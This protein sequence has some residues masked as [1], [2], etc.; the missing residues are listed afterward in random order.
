MGTATPEEARE[1]IR[2]IQDKVS[3]QSKGGSTMS[4]SEAGIND[5]T[6]VREMPVEQVRRSIE[7]VVMRVAESI[8]KGEAF[9][10]NVPNRSSSNQS[11]IPELDRV[12]LRSKASRRSFLSQAQVRKTTI[13][14]RVM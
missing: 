3:R 13:M 11:Y 4:A 7:L 9:G 6:E 14:T 5:V 10:Y 12:V 8:L 1:I 2:R